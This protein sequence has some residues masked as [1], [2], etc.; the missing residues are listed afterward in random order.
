MYK[1]INDNKLLTL[2]QSGF[3]QGDSTVNQL[4]CITNQI[5]TAFEEYPTRETR[6]V[7]LYF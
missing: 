3:R 5:Y 7:F 6:A 1:H 4:L 2:N